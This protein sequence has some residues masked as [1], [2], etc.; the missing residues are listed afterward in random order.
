MIPVSGWFILF[1]LVL[2]LV[3][4]SV[5]LYMDY[6]NTSMNCRDPVILSVNRIVL[7]I[8]TLMFGSSITLMYCRWNCGSTNSEWSIAYMIFTLLLSILLIVCG[9]ISN[10]QA[11][12]LDC[13]EV[14]RFSP[15]IW[16]LG[17]I[18]LISSIF[19]FWWIYQNKSPEQL[20]MQIEREEER[21]RLEEENARRAERKL[22]A[23]N[24]LRSTRE[25]S[26]GAKERVK[27]AESQV[28]NIDRSMSQP[29]STPKRARSPL[30][31]MQP[32][33]PTTFTFGPEKMSTPLSDT[34]SPS[35]SPE[36]VEMT[37]LNRM[38]RN[39]E[40]SFP[41][42]PFSETSFPS[43]QDL[44]PAGQRQRQRSYGEARRS[45]NRVTPSVVDGG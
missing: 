25:R 34:F 40:D 41:M 39:S 30:P 36:P 35:P 14:A 17:L 16:G 27:K 11:K 13:K 1:T 37:T 45:R 31:P 10:V 18:S 20:E 6:S 28:R 7:I 33:I 32:K 4:M 26:V 2:G 3:L 12:K 21:A 43:G 8:G 42:S 19:G 5:V 24:R 38:R 29:P 9:A 22:A 44:F 15:V 23:K